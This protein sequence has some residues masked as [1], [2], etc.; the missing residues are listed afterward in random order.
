VDLSLKNMNSRLKFTLN[1][2]FL[3]PHGECDNK[4]TFRPASTVSFE[5]SGV[6]VN[7]CWIIVF[8]IFVMI[9]GEI[10]MF[11]EDILRGFAGGGGLCLAVL[12][13]CHGM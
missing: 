10:N 1:V 12:G 2:F 5:Y 11:E 3:L 13:N 4:R 8:G 6:F 7:F 9:V